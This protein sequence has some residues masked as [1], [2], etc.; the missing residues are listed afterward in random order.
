[1]NTKPATILEAEEPRKEFVR[2]RGAT[3]F[4][5]VSKS[6]FWNHV[7]NDPDAPKPF[8]VGGGVLLWKISDLRAWVESKG[9]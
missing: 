7:K 3:G 4:L 6:W 5:G 2:T 1:M 9:T 8:R